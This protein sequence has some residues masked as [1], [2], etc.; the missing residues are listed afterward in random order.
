M[1]SQKNLCADRMNS[2]T[3]LSAAQCNYGDAETDDFSY[4]MENVIA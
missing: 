2:F 1:R 4:S 3:K